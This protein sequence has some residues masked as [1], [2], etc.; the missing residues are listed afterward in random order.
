MVKART[1][2]DFDEI[3]EYLRNKIYPPTIPARDYESKSSLRRA[4]KR[5]KVKDGHLFYKKRLVIKDKERQMAIIRDMHQ[6]IGDSEHCKA[7]ALHRGKNTTYDKTVQRFFWHNIAAAI[8]EYVK[9]CEQCQKQGDLKSPK[10]ELKSILVPSSMMKQIGV[11]ICNLPKIDGY[12]HVIVLTE[13]FPKW[14]E[15]KP[16]KD[17]SAPTVAQFLYGVMCRHGCFEIQITNQGQ[18]FVNEV[19][20]QIHELTVVEQRV[21][22]A[23]Q[24]QANGLVERQNRTIKNSLVKVLE[25][26]PEM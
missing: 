23:Y 16:T 24:P 10:V 20:K 13:Y 22:S 1:Y 14:S 8:N 25:D 11:D 2:F 4:T 6:G 21:M 15:P 17:K 7:M 18:E 26:N 5:C 9:S 3:E 12:R 19:C